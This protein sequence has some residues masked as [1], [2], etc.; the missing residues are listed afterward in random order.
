MKKINI[1]RKLAATFIVLALIPAI[2]FAAPATFRELINV[3]LEI[4]NDLVRLVM[5]L[6]LLFFLINVFKLVFA[7]GDT[8]KIEE[9]KSFMIYGIIAL[10]VMVS[11]WGFVNILVK[12]FFGTALIIPQLK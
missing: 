7:G 2:T 11:V 8:K 10:F 12:T 1:P 3:I 9:A 6:A 4:I 5:V